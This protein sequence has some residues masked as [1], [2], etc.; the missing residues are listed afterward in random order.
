MKQDKIFTFIFII[1]LIILVSFPPVAHA[2]GSSS[3][4]LVIKG[5]VSNPLNL[6]YSELEAFPMVS[7]IALLQCVGLSYGVPYKWTGIPLFY[8]L[9]LAQVQPF[10]KEV[11]FWAEDGF[12]SSLTLD[13]A[14]HPATLLAL[15][16]NDTILPYDNSYPVGLPGGYPY[17]VVVPCKYGYKWVGWIDEIEVVDY[18]YKGY[19]ET[20]GFSDE[21]DIPGA[22][23]PETAPTYLA[24]NATWQNVY[25]VTVFSNTTITSADFNQSMKNIQ[26]SISL[27]NAS[28]SLVYI[29][30][31]K[32]LLAPRFTLL[33]DSISS[34]Y[35][36]V[37]SVACS[38]LQFVLNSSSHVIELYG[39]ILAD[40]NFD[41]IV[42]MSDVG[43]VC[44]AY[45]AVPSSERWDSILDLYVC[46]DAVID[47]NDIGFASLQYG[48]QW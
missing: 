7:E 19:Y 37:Q 16:V 11:I 9:N 26:F 15:K 47:M 12:S 6:T 38:F 22:T 34:E 23:L 30:I 33:V 10:A 18:D 2:Q 17:K 8:L 35:S 20:R 36:M 21:A 14:M 32:L 42:D 29:I 25:T 24:F 39:K 40:V 4:N 46:K 31:P 3:D 28:Q 41:G 27:G 1:S 43:W 5:L 13:K 45:G 48:R 44:W